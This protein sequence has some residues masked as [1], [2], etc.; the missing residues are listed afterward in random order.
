MKVVEV[1]LWEGGLLLLDQAIGKGGDG[2]AG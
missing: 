2:P 1:M